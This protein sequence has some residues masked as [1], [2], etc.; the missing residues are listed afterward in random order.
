MFHGSPQCHVNAINCPAWDFTGPNRTGG[1][2]LL[3]SAKKS[4]EFLAQCPE[5][6]LD[7]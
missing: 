4:L 6:S 3:E 7:Q 2:F 1:A 5:D